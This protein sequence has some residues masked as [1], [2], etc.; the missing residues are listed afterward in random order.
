[1]LG[2]VTSMDS[3][4]I[5]RFL[6]TG[7]TNSFS[8]A[9]QQH[10]QDVVQ[11]VF[12]RRA[13][14]VLELLEQIAGVATPHQL[15]KLVN[16]FQSK[17]W[18]LARDEQQLLR[19]RLA[20]ILSSITLQAEAP[21][22]RLEAAG[23]LRLLVQAAYLSQPGFIFSTLVMAATHNPAIEM[24]ERRAYLHML[25]DCFWPFRQPYAAYSW[26]QLPQIL[27]FFP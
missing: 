22:L 1:M 19:E 3:P 27:P 12:S 20:H 16:R 5:T 15:N 21:A 4:H 18:G 6:T 7:Y 10:I 17:V 13:T 14:S 11:P 26:E 23:W 8:S 24:A 2:K 25:V 9:M